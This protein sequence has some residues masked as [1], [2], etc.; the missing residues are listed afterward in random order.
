MI[1]SKYNSMIVI[2]CKNNS[3]LI[4]RTSQL[5]ALVSGAIHGENFHQ[6]SKHSK[7]QKINVL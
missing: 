5:G 4:L 3:V 2:H 1:Q 7:F 6:I